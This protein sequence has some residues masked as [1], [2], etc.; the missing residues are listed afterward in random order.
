[1]VRNTRPMFLINVNHPLG[2]LSKKTYEKW[3]SY[4]KAV[5]L[6]HSCLNLMKQDVATDLSDKN[7]VG[8]KKPAGLF[9]VKWYFTIVTRE[10][11]SRIYINK[12][13]RQSGIMLLDV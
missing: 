6:L 12:K 1:M 2:D 7:I 13:V 9:F 4:S 3:S 11:G 8:K 10:I 5:N